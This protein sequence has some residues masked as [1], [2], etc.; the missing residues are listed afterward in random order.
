MDGLANLLF[1]NNK[2]EKCGCSNS[3]KGESDL[4]ITNL[5]T[6]Q[7]KRIKKRIKNTLEKQRLNSAV[8]RA[9]AGPKQSIARVQVGPTLI[10]TQTEPKQRSKRAK[11]R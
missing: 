9:F 2:W 11:Q 7:E 6:N 1:Q 10:N 3:Q 4:I 5:Q 8:N